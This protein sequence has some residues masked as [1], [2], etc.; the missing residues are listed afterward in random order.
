MKNEEFLNAVVGAK[1]YKRQR[2]NL[3]DKHLRKVT[4]KISEE[5]LHMQ[6]AGFLRLALGDDCLW[7][8][9]ET[10]NQQGGFAGEAKQKK[11]KIKG[12]YAGYPDIEIKYMVDGVLHELCLELKTNIG[13]VS[14]E[15]K[16]CHIRL[17]RLNIPTVICRS[18]EDV[19]NALSVYNVP[20]KRIEL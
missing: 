17:V 13:V 2:K 14:L 20:H 19:K 9:I 10:S 18:L 5:Q 7:H 3:I 1:N 11:L 6:V 12:V 8:T 15:Q 4:V 16:A